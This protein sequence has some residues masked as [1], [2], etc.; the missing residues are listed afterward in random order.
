M[1]EN[2]EEKVVDQGT[3]ALFIFY[4]NIKNS[5]GN[6]LV[7]RNLLQEKKVWGRLLGSRQTFSGIKMILIGVDMLQQ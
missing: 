6:R 5:K 7:V 1:E 2:Q 4:L 3:F